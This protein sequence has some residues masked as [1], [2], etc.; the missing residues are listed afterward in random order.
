[1]LFVASYKAEALQEAADENA[2]KLQ[3]QAEES[4]LKL[5]R[6]ADDSARE[7][8]LAQGD[9]TLRVAQASII[10]PLIDGLLSTDIKKRKLAI[11]AVLIA[12]PV[13]GPKLVQDLGAQSEDDEVKSYA[14][15]ALNE[16]KE[17]LV[18]DLYAGDEGASTT[19]ARA[20]V[21]GWKNDGDVAKRL[22]TKAQKQPENKTGV[23][24]S[25]L[26]LDGLSRSALAQNQRELEPLLKAAA[27]QQGTKT[28]I[29][30]E[31]VE[32]KLHAPANPAAD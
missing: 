7:R 2:R 15:K 9:M 16:R 4:A 24:N 20:L 14:E 1:L 30:A 19:A 10:P 18:A 23:Y 11:S 26:V 32:A 12:L 21:S 13:D 25:I 17:K 27:S 28:A 3:E 29:Q 5:Q 31:R 6:E 8:G 22:I